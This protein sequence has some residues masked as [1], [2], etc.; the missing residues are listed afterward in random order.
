MEETGYQNI[1]IVD[2]A[3]KVGPDRMAKQQDFGGLCR[4]TPLMTRGISKGKCGEVSTPQEL[5]VV[6]EREM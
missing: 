4:I 2:N 1:I 3:P 5:R 6:T